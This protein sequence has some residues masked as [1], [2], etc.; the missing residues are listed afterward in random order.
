[1]D[2]RF[3]SRSRTSSHSR[4]TTTRSAWG[5]AGGSTRSAGTAAS[6]EPSA[7]RF[8]CFD[9][10]CDAFVFVKPTVFV[11]VKFFD[12]GDFRAT[13]TTHSH[14]RFWEL[15]FLPFQ[16]HPVCALFVG[17]NRQSLLGSTFPV[18]FHLAWIGWAAAWGWT[19]TGASHVG[20]RPGSKYRQNRFELLQLFVG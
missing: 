6:T 14:L 11:R 3:R 1:M 9:A 20:L 2:S 7:G 4:R 13:H 19:K 16:L 15:E 18:R 8:L 17:K 12:Q 10:G 5:S